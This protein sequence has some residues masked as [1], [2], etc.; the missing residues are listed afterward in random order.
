MQQTIALTLSTIQSLLQIKQTQLQ[1]VEDRGYVISDAER[2]IYDMDVRSFV[3]FLNNSL[4]SYNKLVPE[5]D[6]RLLSNRKL[7]SGSYLNP[8]KTEKMVVFFADHDKSTV[9]VE[10]AKEFR[11]FLMSKGVK[12]GIIIID[13]P[14]SPS[15]VKELLPITSV[16]WQVFNDIDL[17]Y[18]PTH[19]ILYQK[20]E[21]ISLEEEPELLKSMRVTKSKLLLIKKNDPIIKYFNW[22]IG[23]VVRIYR[24]NSALS[25]LTPYDI[26]YRVIVG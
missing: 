8:E 26:N 13:R 20:H 21:L 7:L 1:M 22:E 18:N 4:E 3:T 6:R 14:L 10:E 17:S 23:R 2:A 5:K 9:S 25:V 24:D 19:H 12:E 15:S 11:A 16:K